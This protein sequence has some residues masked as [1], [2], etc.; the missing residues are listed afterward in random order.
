MGGIPLG[1][2]DSFEEAGRA[3]K[4]EARERRLTRSTC[5]NEAERCRHPEAEAVEAVHEVAECPGSEPDT[6]TDE[7]IGRS[8]LLGKQM[9]DP[10][11]RE[12]PDHEPRT[13]AE[14]LH[15]T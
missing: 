4:C 12:R 14:L 13:E 8:V 5:D 15:S 1:A 2:G 7:R 10:P 6:E 3:R 11:C 9:R